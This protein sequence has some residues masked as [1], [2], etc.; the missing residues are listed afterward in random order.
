MGAEIV[1]GGGDCSIG[2]TKIAIENGTA[3]RSF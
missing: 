2:E 1:Y 3:K